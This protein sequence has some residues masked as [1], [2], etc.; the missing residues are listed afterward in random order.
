LVTP[1]VSRASPAHPVI[2]EAQ[3]IVQVMVMKSIP[4][5]G[6]CQNPA[7]PRSMD[8]VQINLPERKR[9][10]RSRDGKSTPSRGA[11]EVGALA[12]RLNVDQSLKK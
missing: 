7:T 11:F 1:N 10:G 8:P 12:I 9:A 3:G 2:F 5:Q 6:S 4:I